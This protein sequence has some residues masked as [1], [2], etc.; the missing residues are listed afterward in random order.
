V[1]RQRE[2]DDVDS[3]GIEGGL[4]GDAANA[5]GAKELLHQI[6]LRIHYQACWTIWRIAGAAVR[7]WVNPALER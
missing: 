5:V 6:F 7:L 1:V 2:A 4:A 3:G